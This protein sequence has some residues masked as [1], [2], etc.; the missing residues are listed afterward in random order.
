LRLIN[1]TDVLLTMSQA[2]IDEKH[3][4]LIGTRYVHVSLRLQYAHHQYSDQSP[5]VCEESEE[6]TAIWIKNQRYAICFCLE[7]KDQPYQLVYYGLE[8]RKND[9]NTCV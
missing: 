1:I 6:S 8:D 4:K 7:Q 5:A 9:H 3:I 2:T